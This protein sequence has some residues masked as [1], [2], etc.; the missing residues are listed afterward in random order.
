MVGH[1]AKLEIPKI[2]EEKSSIFIYGIF[3]GT[4]YDRKEKCQKH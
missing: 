2:M 1:H 3:N 4:I